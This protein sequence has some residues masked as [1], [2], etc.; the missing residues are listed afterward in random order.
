MQNDK[1]EG[2]ADVAVTNITEVI[3]EMVQYIEQLE[4]QLAEA[5]AKLHAFKVAETMGELAKLQE[6]ENI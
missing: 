4:Q 2:R 3:N 6:D 1:L 5:N